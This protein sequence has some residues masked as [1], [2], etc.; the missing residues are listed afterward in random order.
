MVRNPASQQGLSSTLGS[1][2][3]AV[4]AYKRGG[5]PEREEVREDEVSSGGEDSKALCEPGLLVLPVVE[6]RGA[7]DEVEGVV[8]VGQFFGD[9]GGETDASVVVGCVGDRDHAFCGVD[10]CQLLD[11]GTAFGQESEKKAGSA[12][13]VEHASGLG[14]DLE[15]H[16]GGA[17]GD[18]VV[19]S[20]AIAGLV[21]R[22]SVV[23]GLDVSVIGHGPIIPGA[24]QE[25][26]RPGRVPGTTAVNRD[27]S[28]QG[29]IPEHHASTGA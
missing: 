15:G 12:S 6:R 11:V 18:V 17:S 14:F 25:A 9:S 29:V 1:G 23:E 24:K 13:D 8:G 5:E 10:S 28:Y 21:V 4:A 26:S 19:H 27:R 20:S 7:D 16:F 22:G 2:V 3:S